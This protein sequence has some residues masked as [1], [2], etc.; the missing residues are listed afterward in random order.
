MSKKSHRAY[1]RTVGVATRGIV[2]SSALPSYNSN[3]VHRN[4]PCPCGSKLKYK[5]CHGINN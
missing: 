5:R 1:T 4:D 3:K 2:P